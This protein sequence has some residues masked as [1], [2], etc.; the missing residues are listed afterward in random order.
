LYTFLFTWQLATKC[1]TRPWY[2]M[3]FLEQPK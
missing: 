1:L 3:V 2:C